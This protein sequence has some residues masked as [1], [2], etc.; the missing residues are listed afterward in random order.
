LANTEAVSTL[1]VTGK[2]SSNDRMPAGSVRVLAVLLIG[3]FVVIL[4]E[5]ALS[6][7]LSRIMIDLC[8]A[9]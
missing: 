4:N 9:G 2:A 8:I 5:T 7:A 1:P 3:A 6:V